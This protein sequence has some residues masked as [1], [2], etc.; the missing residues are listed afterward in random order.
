MELEQN[1]IEDNFEL[2]DV[3]NNIMET[4]EVMTENTDLL[5]YQNE[6]DTIFMG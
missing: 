3:N 1:F 2:S 5:M 6:D 4:E